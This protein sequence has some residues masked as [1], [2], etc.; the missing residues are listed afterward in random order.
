MRRIEIP[1]RWIQAFLVF[2]LGLVSAPLPAQAWTSLDAP[3][4]HAD[5]DAP[6]PH[7]YASLSLDPA[8]MAL[9]RFGVHAEMAW[10][11]AQS[12]WLSPS[13]F[14]RD[15]ERALNLAFGYHLWP[16]AK[17]LKGLFLGPRVQVRRL[18]L[19]KAA[20]GAALGAELGYQHIWGGFC[21]GAALTYDW[22]GLPQ[23]QG[24]P[25]HEPGAR[26]SLGYAWL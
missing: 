18:Y 20:W 13:W 24:P 1:R 7:H 21:L 11:R 10:S 25:K 16:L 2:T 12:V 26:L 9:L 6:Q 8:A 22:N 5:L 15:F 19:E 3:S 17:G 4:Q 23:H 14:Q